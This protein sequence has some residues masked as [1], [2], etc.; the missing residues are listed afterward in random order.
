MGIF[1]PIQQIEQGREQWLFWCPGCREGHMVQTKCP[2]DATI[3][4]A[5]WS[6]NG[7]RE[8]PTV[9]PS[10]LVHEVKRP[11]GTVMQPRCHSFVEAGKIRFLDDCGHVLKGQTVPMV[12]LLNI[13]LQD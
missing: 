12:D 8:C 4:K 10:I 5:C 9:A 11:D 2:P 7:N 13:P 3:S 1:E 6:F